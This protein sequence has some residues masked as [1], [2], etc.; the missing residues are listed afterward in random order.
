[1]LSISFPLA[2]W[3]GLAVIPV[4]IFYFLRMRFRKQPV[5]SIYLW[6]RLQNAVRGANRLHSRTIW[7]LLLQLLCVIAAALTVAEPVWN[8]G[9]YSRPGVIY[10]IDASAS[11]SATEKY[12]PL[13]RFGQAKAR[14]KDKIYEQ[15]GQPE[16]MIFLCASGITPLGNPTTDKNQL[17]SRLDPV[18]AGSAAFDET[19]VAGELQAWLAT[20]KKPWR[21]VLVTDGG[22]DLGGRKLAGLFGG[23]LEIIPVGRGENNVGITA[24]RIFQDPHDPNKQIA[25]F[26]IYN[27][28][29]NDQFI[30][31]YLEYNGK[32]V[33]E[34]KGYLKAPRGLSSQTLSFSG[35]VRNGIY[36]IG[37]EQYPD[38]IEA[39]NQF[40]LAV[41]RPRRIR[42]LLIGNNNPFLRA[43]FGDPQKFEFGLLEDFPS[44]NF[45]GAEWDLVVVDGVPIPYNIRC[46]LLAFGVA[47][48]NK[49]VVMGG[50]VHGEL[51]NVGSSHPLL[52]FTDWDSV[53]IL[54][55]RS[56]TVKPGVQIMA[57][58]NGRPEIAAWE[59]EGW[60]YAIF[61]TD[62]YRS[63]LGLSGA[64]P[65]FIQNLLQWCVPQA[66]NPLAYTLTVGETKTFA[67]PPTWQIINADYIDIK[68]KG[69][70]LTLKP[71]SAGVFSWGQGVN[72]GYIA[73]N[74]PAEELNIAPRQLNI[75]KTERHFT[76][77]YTRS[78]LP[79]GG[80]A[81]GLFLICLYLEWFLWRG[82]PRRKE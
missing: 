64:F 77:E 80:L 75:P 70:L 11:M 6:S 36:K 78:V 39:D 68:R 61:G 3:L 16:G 76:A 23:T 28:W 41:N 63:N 40:V 67:E 81:L 29:P 73:A 25:R 13:D 47:P 51:Q 74:P 62:L 32:E 34:V 18:G 49:T 14:I 72:R 44:D 2:W 22:L 43:V 56:L 46:N 55:G 66:N 52:R 42:I 10:L 57:T 4:L 20:H 82:L 12:Q 53:Q 35:P 48:P 50:P 79:F 19:E 7:L 26:Q 24:L 33:A 1:M 37:L 9:N 45:N 30:Q 31:T 17:V 27:G 71:L 69:P 59:E 58:V 38:A 60:H 65:V 15:T 54:D 8:M 5:S 21:A